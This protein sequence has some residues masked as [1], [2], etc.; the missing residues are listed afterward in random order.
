[1]NVKERLMNGLRLTAVGG[2]ALLL[3]V[4]L[5]GC[6]DYAPT[7][8][9]DPVGSNTGDPEPTT[10][11]TAEPSPT[12]TGAQPPPTPPTPTEPATPPTPPPEPSEPP[13]GPSEPAEPV[14]APEPASTPEP[15]G[16]PEAEPEPA[17]PLPAAS[18]DE[19]APCGG[20]VVGTWVVADCAQ[21]VTGVVDMLGFGLG[22]TMGSVESGSLQVGGTITFNEDGTY[23]DNT[24]T[25][26]DQE[27][28]MPPDCLNVSGTVTTCDRVSSPVQSS[29]G[30]EMFLCVD[31]TETMGCSCSGTFNQEGGIALIALDASTD[32]MYTTMDTTLSL[33]DSKDY[34][35]CVTDGVMVM[36]LAA[37]GKTGTVMGPIVL[38]KQ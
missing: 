17:E 14:P 29:L 5:L 20:D 23:T 10:P 16:E 3:A 7:E 11:G 25:S 34:S 21:T 33:G 26:G 31:N 30:Y 9:Q 18:C 15:A 35:Y 19:V 22:C 38:Q 2:G 27:V 24:T 1:M 6:G 28:G 13:P 4:Q 37:P 8:K 32:G 12:D 36:N